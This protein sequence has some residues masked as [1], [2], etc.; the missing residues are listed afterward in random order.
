MSLFVA[1]TLGRSE[2]RILLSNIQSDEQSKHALE[3]SSKCKTVMD[4]AERSFP[5]HPGQP[6]HNVSV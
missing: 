2:L 3:K 5:N 1:H 6:E 4:A